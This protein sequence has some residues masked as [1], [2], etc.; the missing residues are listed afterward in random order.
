MFRLLARIRRH[1]APAPE[2]LCRP[3]TAYPHRA[4]A[5]G[6]GAYEPHTPHGPNQVARVYNTR[7]AWPV[8]P[9]GP[10]GQRRDG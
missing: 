9:R 7:P 6:T 8:N 1:P 2:P 4:G 5:Y 10:R 3:A